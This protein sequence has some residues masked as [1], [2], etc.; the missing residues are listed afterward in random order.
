[1]DQPQPPKTDPPKNTSWHNSIA[2]YMSR[3]VRH[4]H[5]K[6][7]EWYR[8]HRSGCGGSGGGGGGWIYLLLIAG[9]MFACWLA[10]HV[11]IWLVDVIRSII[12]GVCSCVIAMVPVLLLIGIGL[13][14]IAWYCKTH[15]S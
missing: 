14:G 9:V 11:F 2:C 7:D 5:A 6:S 4:I 8:V 15:R 12:Q 3:H 1:M 13:I 10:Y